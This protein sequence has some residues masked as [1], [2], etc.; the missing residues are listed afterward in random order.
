MTVI[1]ELCGG[2]A[3]GQ[4][5]ELLERPIEYRVSVLRSYPR[6]WELDTLPFGLQ[7]P[8]DVVLYWDTNIC[9]REGHILYATMEL[10]EQLRMAVRRRMVA[11]A[12]PVEQVSGNEWPSWAAPARMSGAKEYPLDAIKHEDT[13][14]LIAQIDEVTDNG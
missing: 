8:Y 12:N 1:I 6:Y 7:E 4:I 3:E 13:E 9:T 10:F 2:P 11:Q 5:V 14:R